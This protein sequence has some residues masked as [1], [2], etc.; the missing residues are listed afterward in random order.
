MSF[1]FSLSKS[2]LA[3]LGS[4]SET[5]RARDT[6]ID[7]RLG[8]R[9]A[10]IDVGLSLGDERVDVR[11]RFSYTSVDVRL[12]GVDRLRGVSAGSIDESAS[13]RLGVGGGVMRRRCEVIGSLL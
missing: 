3:Y 6:G 1:N 13:V 10:S 8:F 9:N 11:L 12:G 5:L 2:K 4:P 7:V